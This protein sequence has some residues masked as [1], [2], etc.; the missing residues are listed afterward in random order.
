LSAWCSLGLFVFSINAIATGYAVRPQ[1][2]SMLALVLLIFI[3]CRI[4]RGS[5]AW[6]A[7]IP[8]LFLGWVNTHG[9]FLAG[10]VVVSAASV[11]YVAQVA[12]EATAGF[13]SG[14]FL[15]CR[16]H[17]IV[18]LLLP[19][20]AFVGTLSNPWGWRMI[21]WTV[22]S[23]LLPRP[24]I[25]EWHSLGFSLAGL[26]LIAVM[27]ATL[28]SW[29]FSRRPNCWWE[30]TVLFVLAVMA[31]RSQRHTPLFALA[32]LMLTPVH[33]ADAL[34]RFARHG[35]GLVAAF[36]RPALQWAAASMLV[37]AAVYAGIQSGSY[38]R[39]HPF[40]LE[41]ERDVFPESAVTF[42]SEN[43]LTGNTIT[44]FDWGQYV[45]WKLPDNP[46]SFDGRLDT[47]YSAAIMDAHWRLYAG[48]DPG[49]AL[50][51]TRAEIALIPSSSPGADWLRSAGWTTVYRDDLAEVLL[52]RPQSFPL[53]DRC[54]LPFIARSGSIAGRSLF[55]STPSV[56]A[57]RLPPR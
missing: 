14:T 16:R 8:F 13:R 47:V 12:F 39:I 56:L 55:P 50:D 18:W 40:T 28:W 49:P 32:N 27:L 1:L 57:S 23:V 43:R 17:P 51:L 48:K 22:A 11:A 41:V 10:L 36:R 53:L 21:E 20:F 34:Q 37:C 52:R 31:L 3:M 26:V 29:C 15:K 25:V 7:V 45:L 5:V 24:N 46:V 44:F 2:F 42:I 33:L 19:V 54:R 38:P 35:Q 9:G 4:D 6:G 30:A